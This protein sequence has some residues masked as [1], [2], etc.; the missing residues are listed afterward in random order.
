MLEVKMGTEGYSG[1]EGSDDNQRESGDNDNEQDS[2]QVCIRRCFS[3]IMRT[4]KTINS[5]LRRSLYIS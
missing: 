2:N 3:E 1:N 5:E 4:V